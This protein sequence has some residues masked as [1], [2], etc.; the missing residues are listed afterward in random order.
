MLVTE[1][2]RPPASDPD[3][4]PVKTWL[5]A[6]AGWAFDFYDL[7]LFSFLLIPIGH[8]LGLTATQEAWL[9]GV[10]LGGSGIGGIVFGYLSDLHGRKT[11]MMWTILLYS[12]GTALTAFAS[13]PWT[14]VLFRLITG[15]GV[16][17]E[18]A[19]GHAL[20]AEAS[21]ARMRGRASALLQSGEPLGVAL[22]ALMGLFAT[23]VLGW[24]GVFLVSSASAA[25][26][27]V[28]RRHI[29][30][31]RLWD[32]QR[33]AH[34]NPVEALRRLAHARLL[35]TLGKGFVLGVLKLGTYWTCYT[36]LPRFLQAPEFLNQPIAR[37]AAWI[38]TAQL[39]QFLGMLAFGVLA[40]RHGRRQAF[41][42][43]SLLTAAALFPIAFHGRALVAEPVLFWSL[44]FAMGLG[45]GCTA[46]FGALLAELFPTDVRNVA[47]GTA[48]NTARGVQ[49][50]APIV[51]SFFVAR[52]GLPGGL[53]VPVV[54]A[55][56]TAAWVWTLPETRFRDLG[57]IPT[58]E[59]RVP[60]PPARRGM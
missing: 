25:I 54:L 47:M 58:D 22:A 1:A 7:V 11:V 8:E 3:R 16:G 34:L 40:D 31:S 10:A 38:V 42:G 46:G 36:W 13:G 39:G 57:A 23:P 37:S 27:I 4:F 44:L 56:L 55:V 33:R 30:E 2:A 18:W 53:G 6:F 41:T 50:F 32:R 5:I 48:Y 35:G 28:V 9:L 43:Y 21:P 49:L 29:P 45:S 51:V 26:A 52:H 17:G 59:A 24:R 60:L 20:L 12:L 15:L 14:L 19:V